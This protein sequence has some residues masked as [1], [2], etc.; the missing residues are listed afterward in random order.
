MNVKL[1]YGGEC[2]NLRRI[3]LL[4]R[5]LPETVVE[6]VE[7]RSSF[8]GLEVTFFIS[9]D[10]VSVLTEKEEKGNGCRY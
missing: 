3:D 1:I 7:G 9:D 2:A 5:V 8:Y 4:K 10:L 6:N